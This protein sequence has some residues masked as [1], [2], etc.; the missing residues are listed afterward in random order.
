M[1]AIMTVTDLVRDTCKAAARMVQRG[2]KITVK[3][4]SRVLFRIVPSDDF[5]TKMTARQYKAFVKD[6]NAIASK[7]DLDSNPVVKLRQER[8]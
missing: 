1:E 6:L 3:S 2:D 8:Q 5:E 7:A 4:G